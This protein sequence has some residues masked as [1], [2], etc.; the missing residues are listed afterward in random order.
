M[1]F[2][3]LMRYNASVYVS[4]LVVLSKGDVD[5]RHVACSFLCLCLLFLLQVVLHFIL[6]EH[7][8]YCGGLQKKKFYARSSFC[9]C[10]RRVL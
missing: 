10:V 2:I 7:E 4:I 9:R 1:V 5:I 6:P 3:C 8:M